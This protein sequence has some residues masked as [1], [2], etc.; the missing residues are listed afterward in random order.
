MP[1]GEPDARPEEAYF[2]ACG[3]VVV[4]QLGGRVDVQAWVE[5]RI[6]LTWVRKGDYR[7]RTFAF[8]EGA[9]L[10]VVVDR[11]GWGW[12][13]PASQVDI[14]LRVPHSIDLQV[15]SGAGPVTVQ[16][17]RGNIRLATGQGD[18]QVRQTAGS[19]SIETGSGNLIAQDCEGTMELEAGQGT[20]T[21][22]GARGNLELD[23]GSGGLMLT[24]LAGNVEADVGS[25][26]VRISCMRGDLKLDAGSGD[27]I[28]E[29]VTSRGLHVETGSG[30]LSLEGC[31]PAEARWELATGSGDIRLAIPPAA[32]CR[33]SVEAGSGLIECRLPLRTREEQP[34]RLQG[35]L[36]RPSATIEV[37]TGSGH[38]VLEASLAPQPA[39]AREPDPDEASL[40][41]LRMVEEGKITP[42][43]AEALLR[44]LANVPD[45]AS[46]REDSA[47]ADGEQTA[48]G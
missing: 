24:D 12:G 25:G 27:V 20:V 48:S 1:V 22:R 29:N 13:D 44:A 15:D 14:E 31:P 7:L 39:S 10:K 19:L 11:P 23:T 32:D 46:P 35:V 9:G 38:V 28:L 34:G 41:V 43:E 37:L 21:V 17:I 30:D 42:G 47:N 40:S 3:Q 26:R 16:G 8:R 2:D 36:N 5:D 4:E 45:P 33:L 18:V 6:R